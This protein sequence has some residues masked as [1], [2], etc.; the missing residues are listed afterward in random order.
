MGASGKGWEV[1][2][3]RRDP[4]RRAGA[5][6][7]GPSTRRARQVAARAHQALEEA[8]GSGGRREMAE[9]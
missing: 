2:G 3:T 7:N 1:M 5:P 6:G 8:E 4:V 9:E